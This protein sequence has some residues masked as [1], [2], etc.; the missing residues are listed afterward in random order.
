M[1]ESV[2]ATLQRFHLEARGEPLGE[3]GGV[4]EDDVVVSLSFKT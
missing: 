3:L 2:P 4:T 1:R